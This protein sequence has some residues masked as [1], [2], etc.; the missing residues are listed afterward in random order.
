MKT[1]KLGLRKQLVNRMRKWCNHIPKHNRKRVVIFM[2]VFY[3]LCFLYVM[4]DAVNSFG[5]N[6]SVK[7]VINDHIKPIP[8][9]ENNLNEIKN[10]G[11]KDNRNESE[12]EQ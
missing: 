6:E 1:R 3:S 5:Q 7:S 4:Y 2:L 8:L 10:Y 12:S 9:I 11:T